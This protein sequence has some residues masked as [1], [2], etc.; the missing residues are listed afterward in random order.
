M[1][2]C[3]SSLPCLALIGQHCSVCCYF[4]RLTLHSHFLSSCSNSLKSN[5]SR[6]FVFVLTIITKDCPHWQCKA[7][8]WLTERGLFAKP[9]Y[10]VLSESRKS[11]FVFANDISSKPETSVFISVWYCKCSGCQQQIFVRDTIWVDIFHCS[12]FFSIKKWL[13]LIVIFQLG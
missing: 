12:T 7:H 3:D 1:F 2:L 8:G 11:L 9:K 10:Y 13:P 6:G 5:L 4:L